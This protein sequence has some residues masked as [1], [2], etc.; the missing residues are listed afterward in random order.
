MNFN[1]FDL[2]Q[3]LKPRLTFEP[4]PD[5][6]HI[7]ESVFALKSFILETKST[8]SS[9][10]ILLL[11]QGIDHYDSLDDISRLVDDISRLVI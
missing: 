1:L 8:I 9:S 4:K 11:D 10:Y 6:S 3:T 2:E 5:L 7:L